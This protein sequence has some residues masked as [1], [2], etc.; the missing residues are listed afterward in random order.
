MSHDEL[1]ALEA[2]LV[3]YKV[4]LDTLPTQEITED[5]IREILKHRGL[6]DFMPDKFAYPGPDDFP[7]SRL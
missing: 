2:K 6:E 4:D 7:S 1:F 3:R 5:R